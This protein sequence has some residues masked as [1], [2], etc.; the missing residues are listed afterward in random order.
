M[1]RQVGQSIYTRMDVKSKTFYDIKFIPV[2]MRRRRLALRCTSSLPTALP[3][4]PKKEIQVT[5]H[6]VYRILFTNSMNYNSTSD[7]SKCI[8]SVY[9]ILFTNSM[10]Y[11]STSD[12][13]KC[14]NY[15]F[16]GMVNFYI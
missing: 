7:M 8:H 2:W 10:N 4:R 11:N 15:I 3:R 1:L 16:F 14:M 9:R 12:M 5:V 13:S 6:S